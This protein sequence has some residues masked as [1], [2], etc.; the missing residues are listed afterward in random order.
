MQPIKA[1][2]LIPQTAHNLGLP[3][4]EVGAVVKLYWKTVRQT[5]SSLPEPVIQ[6]ANLG[7]FQL[8]HWLVDEKIETIE[9]TLQHLKSRKRVNAAAIK[10]LENQLILLQKIKDL[11]QEETLRKTKRKS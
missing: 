1:K 2:E 11:H 6:I 4:G 3:E 7:E 5:L 8:K 10:D 9:E